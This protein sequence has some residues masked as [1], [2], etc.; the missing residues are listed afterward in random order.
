MDRF[1]S[2]PQH[3]PTY[4][5]QERDV[6]LLE[7][8]N[9]QKL[10][11]GQNRI[12][13]YL[14]S[15]LLAA[16]AIGVPL[17][18]NLGELHTLNTV[19]NGHKLFFALGYIWFSGIVLFYCAQLQKTVIIN[20]RKTV[21]LREVLGLDY[22]SFQLV[23]P[24]RRLE[25]ATNPFAISMFPGWRSFTTIPFWTLAGAAALACAYVV[26]LSPFTRFY[27]AMGYIVGMAFL[28]RRWLY[29]THETVRLSLAKCCAWL[30]NLRL[31]P[32]FEYTLYRATLAVVELKRLHYRLDNLENIVVP[33]EDK[34][35]YLHRGVDGRALAR[36]IVSAVPFIRK[37]YGFLRSGGSTITMQ[38]A[39]TLFIADYDKTFRRKVVECLLA[40]WLNDQF[41]KAE[42]L[43]LYIA[44]VR[45]EQNVMGLSAA[46]HHF[47]GPS[48]SAQL[49]A[50]EALFLVERVSTIYS[51]VDAAKVASWYQ[52]AAA[53]PGIAIS[54]PRYQAI[55]SRLRQSGVLS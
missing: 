38:L 4:D 30:L 49:S 12:L 25:G 47:F 31:E 13:E 6:A 41:S 32:D 24:R 46:V 9:A 51:G 7:F 11:V 50:E 19:V 14:I 15:S 8:E 40:G 34:R 27:M 1:E 21:V 44:S 28:Y 52:K 54:E 18:L 39:R 55:Y 20:A 53:I 5:V 43:D 45:F 42:V 35:F 23:L 36:S 26:E 2:L 16:A 22:G 33:I 29:D 48:H 17:L 3:Y 37:R 10:A